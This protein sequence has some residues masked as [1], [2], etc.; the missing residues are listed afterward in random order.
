[1]EYTTLAEV[2]TDAADEAVDEIEA[3]TDAVEVAVADDATA[4][5]EEVPTAD[6]DCDFELVATEDEE[7]M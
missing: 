4:E 6:D 2:M 5:L 3:D 7:V 1:M